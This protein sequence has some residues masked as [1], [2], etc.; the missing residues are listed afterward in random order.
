MSGD[1]NDDG[2]APE[3]GDLTS[4]AGRDAAASALNRARE[5]ARAKGL[6][7]GAPGARRGRAPGRDAPTQGQADSDR[8]IPGTGPGFPPAGGRDPRKLGDS[9]Q[10][11]VSEHGWRNP[12]SVGAVVGR[13]PDVVGQQIADHATPETF[14]DGKL[15][16]RTSSTAW[17][18]QLQLLLP[19]LERKLAEEVG[20]GVVREIVVIGPG[21]PSWV[22]GPRVVKGRGPRDTYG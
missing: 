13:W 20:D 1:E 9:L 6:R 12:I 2:A 7:P 16:I 8:G 19:Q 14:I 17:A 22:K 10:R 15:V 4:E 21:A 3:A 5:A 11:V 18:T